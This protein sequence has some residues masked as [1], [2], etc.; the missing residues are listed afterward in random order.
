MKAIREAEWSGLAE[1]IVK[2]SP[3]ATRGLAV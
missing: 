3:H 1:P 2:V